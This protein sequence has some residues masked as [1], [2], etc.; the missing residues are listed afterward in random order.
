MFEFQMRLKHIVPHSLE[1]R[2]SVEE[3]LVW[4]VRFGN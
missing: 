3:F 4:F 2:M 1:C